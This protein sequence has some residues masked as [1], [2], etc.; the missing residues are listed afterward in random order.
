M[1]QTRMVQ[2]KWLYNFPNCY[3]PKWKQMWA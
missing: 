1:N 3:Q 2:N